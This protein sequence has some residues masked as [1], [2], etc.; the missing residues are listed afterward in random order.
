LTFSL[1]FACLP[2]PVPPPT[3]P[4]PFIEPDS[5]MYPV[6]AGQRHAATRHLTCLAKHLKA[7]SSYGCVANTNCQPFVTSTA[8]QS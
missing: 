8:T 2:Q 6:T 5:F 7:M 3:L 4:A 1:L